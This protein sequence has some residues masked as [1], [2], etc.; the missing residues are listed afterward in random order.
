MYKLERTQKVIII[1][2]CLCIVFFILSIRGYLKGG[3]EI[4]KYGFMNEEF[5]SIMM[6]VC[7]A[8]GI[9]LLLLSVLINVI[10]KDLYEQLKCLDK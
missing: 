8:C 7:F 2:I 1:T 9:I 10:Q 5:Y 3:Y 6:I 4:I